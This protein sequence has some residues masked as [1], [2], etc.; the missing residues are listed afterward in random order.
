MPEIKRARAERTA[1]TWELEKRGNQPPVEP[2]VEEL[3][4]VSQ[5]GEMQ[6]DYDDDALLDTSRRADLP[7]LYSKTRLS[8][9]QRT[10]SETL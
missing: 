10:K 6:Y 3:A 7:V 8:P 5:D 4:V 2:L 1:A 9:N